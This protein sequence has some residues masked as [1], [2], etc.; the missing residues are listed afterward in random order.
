[1]TLYPVSSTIH[2]HFHLK[3]L[4]FPGMNKGPV[5]LILAALIVATTNIVAADERAAIAEDCRMEGDAAG[6]SGDALEAF[7]RE[8][9]EELSGISYDNQVGSESGNDSQ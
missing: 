4:L 3:K 8:C 5:R 2:V 9:V 1:M 6:M 7:V